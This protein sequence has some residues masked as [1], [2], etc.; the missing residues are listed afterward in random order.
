MSDTRLTASGITQKLG[1][2][3]V[4]EDVSLNLEAG[5]FYALVGP[6]GSGKTTLVRTLTGTLSPTDGTVS[7]DGPSAS[8]EIGYL[9]QRPSFRPGFTAR[10]TLE[11]YTALVDGEPDKL[12]DRVGLADASD[13]RVEDLSGGMTRL[14]GLAQATVGN[15]PIVLLDEPGSGLDPTMR[16]RTFD[17]ARELADDGAAVLCSSHDLT[18]VEEYCDRVAMLDAGSLVTVGSPAEIRTTFD[19]PS[20]WKAFDAAVEYS[21]DG[22]DVLGVTE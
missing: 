11:F 18:L 14:L 8:R 9:P 13:R 5:T 17:V 21:K 20:L 16:R 15:P 3:T 7:Y 12:L 4:L 19:E 2:V 6:N 10:E 22:L 1:G